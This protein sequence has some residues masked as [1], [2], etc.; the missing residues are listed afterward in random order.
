MIFF[1]KI[2][3]NE[4]EN[5]SESVFPLVEAGKKMTRT[6]Y[7]KNIVYGHIL[8]SSGARDREL[9][10]SISDLYLHFILGIA[11]R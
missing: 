3:I 9:L 4:N 8:K 1:L 7:G 11:L 6:C 10:R 2:N 5:E